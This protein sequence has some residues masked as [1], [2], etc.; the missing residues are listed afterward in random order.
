[1]RDLLDSDESNVPGKALHVR[2]TG[3]ENIKATNNKQ[4]QDQGVCVNS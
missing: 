1:M 2:S 4:Q 3:Q